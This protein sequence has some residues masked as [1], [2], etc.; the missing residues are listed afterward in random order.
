MR[1]KEQ[2]IKIQ[3]YNK[4]T[5]KWELFPIDYLSIK[6]TQQVLAREANIISKTN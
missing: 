1:Y 4:I 6:A 5:C 3:V 2:Y